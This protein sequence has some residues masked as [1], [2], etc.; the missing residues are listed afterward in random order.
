MLRPAAKILVLDI[1]QMFE[2]VVHFQ[3]RY[4]DDILPRHKLVFLLRFSMGCVIPFNAPLF[5][6]HHC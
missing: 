1:P 2:L 5:A 4:F 3:N 6:E